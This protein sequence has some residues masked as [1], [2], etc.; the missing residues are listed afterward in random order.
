MIEPKMRMIYRLIVSKLLDLASNAKTDGIYKAPTSTKKLI[1]V[2]EA[3]SMVCRE[4]SEDILL[5][6]NHNSISTVIINH[7]SESMSEISDNS[8]PFA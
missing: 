3:I 6:K 8:S 4:I 7:T 1:P 5:T 2:K